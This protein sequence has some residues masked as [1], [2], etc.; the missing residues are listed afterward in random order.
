MQHS[1]GIKVVVLYKA[2]AHCAGMLDALSYY[3]FKTFM[4]GRMTARILKSGRLRIF[5]FVIDCPS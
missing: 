2:A 5:E 4:T 3:V 1:H